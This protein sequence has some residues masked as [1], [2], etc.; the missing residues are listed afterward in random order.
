MF[1]VRFEMAALIVNDIFL[2]FFY[3]TKEK[4]NKAVKSSHTDLITEQIVFF[5]AQAQV[6]I[7]MHLSCYVSLCRKQ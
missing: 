2:F 3:E 5:C 7:E 1:N 6:H 4:L